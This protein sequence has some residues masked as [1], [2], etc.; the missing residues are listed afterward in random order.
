[1]CC[2][3]PSNDDTFGIERNIDVIDVAIIRHW[4]IIDVCMTEAFG[5]IV[6]PIQMCVSPLMMMIFIIM[7]L[8]MMMLLILGKYLKVQWW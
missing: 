4:R 1:M 7:C 6:S 2:Y 3:C 5:I 8:L